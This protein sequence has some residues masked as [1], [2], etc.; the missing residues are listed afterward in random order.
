MTL[1]MKSVPV[2][3]SQSNGGDQ[4][5]EIEAQDEMTLVMK[6]THTQMSS[7]PEELK[8]KKRKAS[9]SL[10]ELLRATAEKK[11]ELDKLSVKWTSNDE[12][13][14]EGISQMTLHSFIL[15]AEELG[16]NITYTRTLRVDI[17]D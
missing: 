2:N 11:G 6:S 7:M 13:E 1:V 8:E 5:T 15:K 16:K 9:P 12:L 17:T 10:D 3:D 14:I 4:L